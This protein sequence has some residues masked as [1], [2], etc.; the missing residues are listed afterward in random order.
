VT[1]RRG[2]GDEF[3]CSAMTPSSLRPRTA[4]RSTCRPSARPDSVAAPRV[5]RHSPLPC[6]SGSTSVASPV[7]PR[8]T[9]KLKGRVLALSYLA[10]C[11]VA[12]RELGGP[13]ILGE[14]EPGLCCAA[15]DPLRD[16]YSHKGGCLVPAGIAPPHLRCTV[17]P[18][19]AECS[20][21]CAPTTD[22]TTA[23]PGSEIRWSNRQRA[24]YRY[25][26]RLRAQGIMPSR[27]EPAA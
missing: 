21:P 18:Y 11:Y 26:R 25:G 1:P 19:V 20:M 2:L 7:V 15:Q 8:K 22:Q 24:V 23:T 4:L 14:R 5:D 13:V 9:M 17:G 10:S 3:F 16:R 27:I 6:P 12:V